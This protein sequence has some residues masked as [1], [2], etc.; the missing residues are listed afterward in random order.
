MADDT[1]KMLVSI[2]RHYHVTCALPYFSGSGM[3]IFQTA[4]LPIVAWY[5]MQKVA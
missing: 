2:A 3:R 5:V 1:P 4:Y